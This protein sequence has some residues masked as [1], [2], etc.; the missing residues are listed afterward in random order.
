[1][2]TKQ[3]LFMNLRSGDIFMYGNELFLVLSN[4]AFGIYDHLSHCKIECLTP[5]GIETV[6]FPNTK[7]HKIK[8]YRAENEL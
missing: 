6:Y 1:M 7:A 8:F 4:I 3:E 2:K 5:R